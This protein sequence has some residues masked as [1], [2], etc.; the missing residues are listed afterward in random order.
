M[1][2]QLPF[3]L[4][5]R[6]IAYAAADRPQ[7]TR[8]IESNPTLGAGE[9]PPVATA[10]DFRL[11]ITQSETRPLFARLSRG[12]AMARRLLGIGLGLFLAGSTARAVDYYVATNGNNAWSGRLPAPNSNR[13]DGPF[14]SLERARDEVRRLKSAGPLTSSVTVQVRDG[15]YFLPQT[16]KLGAPDSGT[17]ENPVVYRGYQDE[18]PVLVG[19]R[20][21][22][23]FKP[24]KGQILQADVGAQGFTGV[25]FRQL[26]LDGERQPLARYPNYDAA[27][28]YGGGWAYADGNY[29]PKYK[30]IPGESRRTFNYAPA[31]ARAWSRPEEGEVFVFPR[32]NW[33]NDILPI[34]SIDRTS[35]RITLTRD[36]SYSIRPTDRYFVRNLF[37]ELDAP[38]EWYL[39]QR[40]WT[41]YFWPSAPLQNKAVYAPTTRTILEIGEGASDITFRNFVFECSEGT[42]ISLHNTSRCLIGS[43][44]IRNVG[45]YD[46]SGVEV[47]GG[48]RNGIVGNDINGTGRSGISISGG[49]RK[50]LTPAENYADNNYI[51]HVGV[52]SKQ[53][54]AISLNG[55]GNRAS[56]N[57]IHDCP[58]T[59]IGFRGN[60]LVI[61][62]NEI[63]HVDLET[64]D[65]AAINTGGRDWISS[66]GSV[67]RYNFVHDVMGYGYRDGKWLSPFLAWGI[68]LD[69]NTGGVDV[70][71]NII[72]RVPRAGIFLHNGRDNHMENNV[73]VDNALQQVEYY[74]WTKDHVY[75]K[76]HLPTMIEGY[77]MV[78]HE[79]AWKTMRNMDIY[80]ADAPVASGL[81]MTGNEFHR[82][83]IYYHDPASR[84]FSFQHVPFDHYQSD[85]N[86]VYHFGQPIL[87]GQ[88]QAG[89]VA[90][91][92]LVPNAEF[93]GGRPDTLAPGWQW[94]IDPAPAANADVA[95]N[96]VPAWQWRTDPAPTA[97]SGITEGPTGKRALRINAATGKQAGHA[98]HP[99]VVSDEFPL[100][101]RHYYRLSVR[102]KGTTPNTAA[103]MM[104]QWYD[105]SLG[106]F[107]FWSTYPC[108]IK[109]GNEWKEHE[110]VFRILGPGDLN[111]RA[112]MK[113]FRFR[114]DFNDG[115]GSLFVTDVAVHE[116]AVPDEWASWQAMGLDTH[117]I[118]ADPLF[119]N[120]AKDDYR[121][122]PASPALKLGFKP[123]AIDQIGP[124]KDSRRATWPIVQAEGAREKPLITD[125]K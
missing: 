3:P 57:L 18:R 77:E 22:T 7:S 90:S 63:R 94:Q 74:G 125:A 116:I 6:S 111:Y 106:F 39:D 64:E 95:G 81:I 72:A 89:K 96:T 42:A 62:Y 16:L 12:T 10:S 65:T 15:T 29:I 47:A 98:D 66:R 112:E 85:Y 67:V 115:A 35:R 118:V 114:I 84:L 99:I 23:G 28:P 71:G 30:D 109:V 91:P 105:P 69:D 86:L 40:T 70:I 17:T 2:Q 55:V 93:A 108:D 53:G 19:G 51:H 20:P 49:D 124:Y 56:H 59:G 52:I 88:A 68:Y 82:N 13:T 54:V 38:G 101:S 80:P 44:I 32:Y 9:P 33:G 123:I 1:K 120:P 73:L 41:L 97:G 43:N 100:E 46:G 4:R 11:N 27:N 119:V 21:I 8:L 78:A 5:S 48:F 14:A 36:A 76:R 110:L 103:K 25:Y 92:N 113:R 83:I 122:K 87:T 31:D 121:L 24:Y 50:T 26:L 61:E 58:R 79:P 34:A 107:G 37:E 102:M 104:L 75:W 45:G 117:S 60:N